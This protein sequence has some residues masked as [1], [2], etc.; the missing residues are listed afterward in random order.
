MRSVL[1]VL[2][3]LH[4]CCV[5]ASALTIVSEAAPRMVVE[6]NGVLWGLGVDIVREL[7]RRTGDASPIGV[8]PWARAY[9]MAQREPGVLI[10]PITRLPEREALFEWLDPFLSL[11]WIFC[12][13][14]GKAPRLASL[15]DARRVGSIGTYPKDAR[16]QYLSAQGFT[17]LEPATDQIANIRKLLAGRID[18]LATTNISL[19]DVR[20][21]AGP[22]GRRILKVLSFKTVDVGLAFSKGTDPAVVRAWREAFAAMR[23][24][25]T[26]QALRERWFPG[27]FKAH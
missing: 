1:A 15:E 4:L 3:V 17:N 12:A 7:Q 24:D 22:E 2:A 20:E 10:L 16:E 13:V 27:V 19:P 11:E 6:E 8:Y 21:L 23:E 14:E 9:A 18:L 5:Q 25:G 26:L